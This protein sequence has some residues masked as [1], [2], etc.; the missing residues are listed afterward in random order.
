MMQV[1]KYR[2]VLLEN[3]LIL[4]HVP[5]TVMIYSVITVALSFLLL[6]PA[7][8]SGI[9]STRANASPIPT[10][11]VGLLWWE[12][13]EDVNSDEVSFHW[14]DIRR[15]RLKRLFTRGETKSPVLCWGKIPFKETSKHH[16]ASLSREMIR[17]KAKIWVRDAEGRISQAAFNLVKDNLTVDV[18]EDPELNGLY[19]LGVHLDM[20]ET[21]IDLDGAA[22]KIHLSAKRLLYHRKTSGHQGNERGAFFDDPDKLPLEIG[23]LD[24]RFRRDYQRAYREYGMKVVYQGKPLGDSEVHIIS[25]SGWRKTVH[26]DSAGEFL[27]TPFGNM[28]K[29]AREKYLYVACYHDLSEREYHCATLAMTI[30]TYPEWLSRS[31]GFMLWTILGTGLS[32]LIIIMGIS[33]KKKHAREAV[34]KFEKQRINK[35]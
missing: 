29:G 3:P 11:R 5:S 16:R 8:P 27:M 32:L 31:H 21:D 2:H 35:G 34:L 24:R 25:G 30:N 28:E 14:K 26:T 22:E 19:L 12:L 33:Q 18:P 17:E 6:F 1:W 15:A 13:E 10:E 4:Y 23:F 20:G 7:Y 9:F